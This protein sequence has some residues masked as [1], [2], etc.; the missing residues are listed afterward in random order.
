MESSTTA[1]VTQ[2]AYLAFHKQQKNSLQLRLESIEERKKRLFLLRNW[3]KANRQAIQQAI[4]S[5]FKKPAEEVDGTEIFHVLA[6]IQLALNNIEQWTSARKVD[7]PFTF[8]GTRSYLKPEPRGVC[9]IIGPWNYPFSLVV[10]PLVSALAAGNSVIIKPSEAT[11]ST[12]ALLTKMVTELFDEWVVAVVEGDVLVSQYLT[13]LPFDHIFFTGSPAVGKL[14]MKAAA[15]N[16]TSVT[17][18]LGGK[19]PAVVTE[20]ARIEETAERLVVAKFVNCGQTCIAPDYVLVDQKI[21]RPFI[22]ALKRKIEKHFSENGE[23]IRESNHYARLV[24][25]KHWQRMNNLLADALIKGAKLEYGGEVLESDNYIQPTLLSEV[26]S[27]S[28]ILE[29]EIFGPL[30]PIVAYQELSEAISLINSKPKPLALYIYS[31][32][33]LQQ[34]QVLTATSSGA[35]CVNDSA[36]H[37][38]NNHL[39]FGGVNSSG[40]GKAH[41]YDGF[42]TFSHVKPILKQRNGFTSIKALYP[43]YKWFGKKIMDILFK[44][45]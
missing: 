29:E 3:I 1:S 34:H 30:L 43:P 41:G 10:G 40:M 38:L 21:L 17:L 22:E 2:H 32:N 24:N 27:D 9:L 35:V 45:T 18:E 19:S 7:A 25:K 14:V 42:L 33:K 28:L 12:A 31:Q 26:S 23:P 15:E 16:L 6:E 11:P 36:I 5:D 13:T 39:P 44:L 20:S 8:L 37:F 4:Y